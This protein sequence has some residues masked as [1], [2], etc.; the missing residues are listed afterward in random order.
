MQRIYL[1]HAASTPLAPTVQAAILPYIGG[2]FGNPS[3]TH[4][5]GRQAKAAIE[6]ARK[7]IAQLLHCQASELIFTAS[8]TEANNMALTCAVRD[9]GVRR[10]LLTPIE[11]ACVLQTAAALQK[12]YADLELIFLPLEPSGRLNF[13]ATIDILKKTSAVPTLVSIIAAHNELGLIN[14]VEELAAIFQND[15]NLYFH[16]DMV[17]AV[18][19]AELN[20]QESHLHFASASAHKF[21]GLRGA[22]F[23]YAR[24]VKGL[25]ALIEGGGQERGLR[26]GTE[27]TAAIVSAATALEYR[28]QHRAEEWAY[29]ENLRHQFINAL[30]QRIPDIRINGSPKK[31]QIFPYI[32]HIALPTRLSLPTLLF[33]IDLQG[34]SASAGAACSAGAVRPSAV[35]QF[36]NLPPTHQPLRLSLSPYN[37]QEEIQRAAE[38]L[39]AV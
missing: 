11:H 10:I 6:Q 22:G 8:A 13:H 2:F 31:E 4:S 19:H 9:W 33:K 12:Q 36:L 37:T 7:K 30:E 21:G 27:D 23:L 24:R 29:V 26:A 14:P 35:S 39:A 34:L 15:P 5:E 28:L 17:Q 3:A 38:I 20:F 32:L 18:G 1:D 16:S 25:S